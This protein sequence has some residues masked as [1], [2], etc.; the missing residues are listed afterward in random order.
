MIKRKE[1]EKEFI[2]AIGENQGILHKIC[3]VYA[4]SKL[5]REDLY[6]DIIFQL[7]K[8]YSSFK[9]R[10]KF[11]TWIYQVALNTAIT[12][13]RRRKALPSGREFSE[14]IY[15]PT[16]AMDYSEDLRILYQAIS[17]LSKVE[18]ALILMWLDEKSYKEMSATLGMSEK[19]VSVSL[20]RIKR[21]LTDLI[22]KLQ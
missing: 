1:V 8:S 20:V 22:K 17:Y 2:R 18:K 11:S 13:V 4:D 12:K 15:S 3:F 19:N 14:E 5:D 9:G 21:K 10:S 7:W 16:I 6:Q